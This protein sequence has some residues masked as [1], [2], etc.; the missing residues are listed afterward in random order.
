VVTRLVSDSEFV[1]GITNAILLVSFFLTG[2]NGMTPTLLPDETRWLVNVAPN[3]LASRLQAW[4][5]TDTP[6]SAPPGVESAGFV[7]PALPVEIQYVGLLAAWAVALAVAAAY[8]MDRAV[9]R[10]EGGE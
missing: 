7:P 6:K 3:S 10:G 5:V 4:H 9:Y 1:V 8:L 2:Y